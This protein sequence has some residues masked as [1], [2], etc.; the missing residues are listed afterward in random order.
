MPKR[1]RKIIRRGRF[2]IRERDNAGLFEIWDREYH[3]PGTVKGHAMPNPIADA[4]IR[5]Y[6]N[7]IRDALNL[8]EELEC[9]A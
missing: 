4:W 5:R 2:F 1:K 9:C 8:S 6:A 3:S 7:K